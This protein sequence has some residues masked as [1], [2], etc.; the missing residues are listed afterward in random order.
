MDGISPIFSGRAVLRPGHPPRPT[1]RRSL[2]VVLA[3][4]WLSLGLVSP[5]Y[6]AS[7]DGPFGS[8]PPD[9][10]LPAAD[11][12]ALPLVLPAAEAARL[13]LPDLRTL[14]PSDLEIVRLP[15]GARE[16]RLSNTIWNSG[17]GPLELEGAANP[18]ALLTRVQQ[19]VLARAGAQRT[20]LVGDFI[21]HPEHEHWHFEDFSV[22]ELWSLAPTGALETL[23]GS[24]EKVSYCVIDTDVVDPGNEGFLARR[25]YFG[26]G[27][28]LQGLSAGWGDTYKSF[29]DGQSIR[30]S[31][32]Q[33][34]IY[35]LKSTAN[36]GAV[37]LE[38]D[39]QNNAALLYLE[40]RGESLEVIPP[41]ELAERRC[42]ENG[43]C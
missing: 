41:H 31:R 36:P 39:Y 34:G 5:G 26:C 33:D 1:L 23:V 37:L 29:L 22:Y 11:E 35:A 28:L 14:P 8:P 40:I 25:R 4:A 24:S 20:H 21:L 17:H 3:F 9:P 2:R 38:A 6:A 15:D 43:W 10:D 16:L 13:L 30:L 19:H 42:S 32:V 12:E 7:P 18:N 27:R